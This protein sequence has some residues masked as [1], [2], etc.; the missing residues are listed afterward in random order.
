M[1]LYKHQ[2][3]FLEANPDR[4]ILT[5]GAGTGKTLT[6]LL[7]MKDKDN[8]LVICPKS[9]KARWI[10][11]VGKHNIKADVLTKEEFKKVDILKYDTIVIDEVHFF[12]S[13]IFVK[14]TSAMTEKMYY[15]VRNKP[16]GKFLGMTAT[17]ISSQP[18]NIHTLLTLSGK[19]ID[20]KKFRSHFYS[21]QSPRYL[22]G[23]F[24]WLVKEGTEDEPFNWRT[25]ARKLVE[26]YT[27]TA[28]MQDIV[29]Y[30]PEQHYEVISIPLSKKEKDLIK[31]QETNPE[32]ES[33]IAIWYAQHRL[34]QTKAKIKKIKELSADHSKVVIYAKYKEQIKELEKSLSSE[35]QVYVM[36][37]ETKD[38]GAVIEQAQNDSECY[39]IIQADIA[40]GYELP[41]FTCVIYASQSWRK[42]SDVQSQARVQRINNLKSN[43]YYWLIAGEKD[44]LVY[45]TIKKGD[46][47]IIK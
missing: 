5:F 23:R 9:L 43:W 15:W 35:R 42:I 25:Q 7:W 44:R 2:K 24:A 30:I 31:E 29:G 33:D 17:P 32:L 27:W 16:Q 20:W 18:W 14:G 1:E 46:D 4:A 45:E 28:T 11:D 39:F 22:K 3:E 6:A 13:P 19:Y 34:E 8:T 26:R 37:G 21:L 41:D 47:F 40:E 12:N 10:K 36:T 38:Q